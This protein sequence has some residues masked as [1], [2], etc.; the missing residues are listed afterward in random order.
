MSKEELKT[1]IERLKLIIKELQYQYMAIQE[2]DQN[3]K[4]RKE[5]SLFNN[6]I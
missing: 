2:L 1:E 5:E 4:F 3:N 6:R